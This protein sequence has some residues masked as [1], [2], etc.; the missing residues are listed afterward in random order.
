MYRDLA[1]CRFGARSQ[2]PV[3]QSIIVKADT[4]LASLRHQFNP[5]SNFGGFHATPPGSGQRPALR[6]L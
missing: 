6:R 5:N 3:T 4:R 2:R 1:V